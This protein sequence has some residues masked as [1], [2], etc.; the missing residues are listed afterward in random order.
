MPLFKSSIS[1]PLP[2]DIHNA[3]V[4]VIIEPADAKAT[5]PAVGSKIA[6]DTVDRLAGALLAV[7]DAGANGAV[8]GGVPTGSGAGFGDIPLSV[9]SPAFVNVGTGG[10]AGRV[11]RQ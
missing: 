6:F 7:Q 5:G 9:V 1:M 4:L 3:V 2:L 8:S 10:L 11:H